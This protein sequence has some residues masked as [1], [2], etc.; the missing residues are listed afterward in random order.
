MVKCAS[1]LTALLQHHCLS[2]SSKL[3]GKGLIPMDVLDWVLTAQG[4]SNQD[5]AARVVSC[6]TN[7]VKSSPQCFHD[8]VD[9]LKGESF[10]A[11]IVE[12]MITTHS[13]PKCIV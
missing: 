5:K 13:E 7:R 8:F 9:I 4:V 1:G 11:D 6:V 10:F 3:L 2:V 12:T